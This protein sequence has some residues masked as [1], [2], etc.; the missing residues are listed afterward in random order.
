MTFVIWSIE[1]DAWWR[2]AEIGYT[3]V[4]GEA[5]LYEQEDAARIVRQANIVHFHECM[6]PVECV[7]DLAGDDGRMKKPKIDKALR[8]ATRRNFERLS[9]S[10]TFCLLFNER[11]VEEVLPLI[12]MGLAVYLDKPIVILAPAGSA[13]PGNLRAMA[14]AIEEFDPADPRSLDAATQRLVRNGKM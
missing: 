7:A 11:M 13:I 1:H 14:T 8:D 9:E 4:L 5:G 2:P 3:R 6:I 10:R 12:Q